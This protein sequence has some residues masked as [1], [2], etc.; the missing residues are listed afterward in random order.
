[1]EEVVEYKYDTWGRVVGM[2]G[3]AYGQWVG[4]LNPFR[5]RGY[6]YDDESGM[7][8]LTTRYYNPEWCRFLNADGIIC[9]NQD[10]MSFN[11][12]VYCSNNY[13]NYCDPSGAFDIWSA[14]NPLNKSIRSSAILFSEAIFG[15]GSKKTYGPNSVL[16]K[17]LSKS[18][19]M[20]EELKKP[21][22]RFKRG[23]RKEKTYKGE[24]S[25]YGKTNKY[26]FDLSYS[27]GKAKYTVT[28]R[29]EVKQVGFWPF[30]K[31]QARYVMDVTV[32]DTYNFDEYRGDESLSDTLNDF[33]YD[34]QKDGVLKPYEWDAKFT[35]EDEW[36][37]VL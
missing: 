12:F 36:R 22:G 21:L 9:A 24:V 26:D 8:Y 10:L 17:T 3:S 5:Y 1:M 37:D 6:Y 15:D 27:V 19:L 28:I 18:R 31:T 11:L 35:I 4:S 33:G 25:L 34:L 16:S 7:Y 13:V 30:K 29:E 2:E 20:M 32:S 23:D 14:I